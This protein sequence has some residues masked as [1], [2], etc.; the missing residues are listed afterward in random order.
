MLGKIESRRRRGR[1]R[2]RWLDG[3][4]DSTDMS[5]NKFQEMVKDKEAQSA[6]VHG[7]AKSRTWLS[8]WTTTI[9]QLRQIKNNKIQKDPKNPS[10]HFW[11]VWRKSK[12]LCM[13]LEHNTTKEVGKP[14]KPPIWP[15]PWINPTFTLWKEP[16]CHPGSGSKQGKLLPCSCFLL[17][18]Q[19]PSKS[20]LNFLSGL[21]SISIG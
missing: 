10:C 16:T 17:L 1:Q 19:E 20:L 2:M 7:V 18:Q 6:A 8:N 12:V 9:L 13:T 21:L 5:L 11:R 14:P 15:N 4:T 3:N